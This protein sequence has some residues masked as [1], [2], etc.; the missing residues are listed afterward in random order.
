MKPVEGASEVLLGDLRL[1]SEE[2]GLE[3]ANKGGGEVFDGMVGYRVEELI[4]L[5]VEDGSSK[6]CTCVSSS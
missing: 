6:C 1:G 2:V 3:M 5:R 4:D